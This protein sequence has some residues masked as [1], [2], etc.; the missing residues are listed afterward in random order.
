MKEESNWKK[1]LK[2][3]QNSMFVSGIFKYQQT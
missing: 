3:I 2:S 1:P